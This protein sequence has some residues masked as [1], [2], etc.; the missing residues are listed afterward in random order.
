LYL[1]DYYFGVKQGCENI[2][3]QAIDSWQS[4]NG[5]KLE[6]FEAKILF[7]IDHKRIKVQQ[8]IHNG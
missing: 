6:P 7:Q 5:F 2:N 4:V 3:W 8:D 1:L